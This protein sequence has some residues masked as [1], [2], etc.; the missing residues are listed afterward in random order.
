MLR[1]GLLSLDKVLLL[2]FLAVL[3]LRRTI[4]SKIAR[5]HSVEGVIKP[6][7]D[8]H[9]VKQTTSLGF[10][11]T[12]DSYYLKNSWLTGLKK[13]SKPIE[14]P[15]D[16]Y[17]KSI[18]KFVNFAIPTIWLTI[19]LA[20]LINKFGDLIY[21]ITFAGCFALIVFALSIELR[22]ITKS[23]LKEI[24]YANAT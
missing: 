3:F 4:K 15:E 16:I 20:I 12:K 21:G 9:I 13:I 6:K 1:N 5:K 11:Y 10:I 17:V 2:I 22:K 7:Y 14:I 8:A 23:V 24:N 19:V 18:S